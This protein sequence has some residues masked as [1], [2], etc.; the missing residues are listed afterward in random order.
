MMIGVFLM[1]YIHIHVLYM[2]K[3]DRGELMKSKKII[4]EVTEFVAGS[5]C[6]SK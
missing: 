4:N 3:I 5:L 6:S 1:Y 2:H